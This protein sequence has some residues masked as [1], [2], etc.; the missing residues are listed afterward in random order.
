MIS[1]TRGKETQ[2]N[3]TYR[4]LPERIITQHIP[5]KRH[6]IVKDTR[7]IE[8]H[9]TE[10]YNM[11]ISRDEIEEPEPI[12]VEKIVEKPIEVLVT[13]K[14]PKKVVR[15][16]Y[17][18]QIVEK[19]IERIIEKEIIIDKIIEKEIIKTVEVPVEK[20]VEV[21]V[22]EIIEKPVE[23]IEYVDI[24]R[25]R[26]QTKVEE[27]QVEIDLFTIRNIDIDSKDIGKYPK[28]QILPTS[29]SSTKK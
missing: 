12:I 21:A 16:V 6:S 14:I 27:P 24:P 13:R 4:E 26:I 22:E 9:K 7:F 10:S 2:I 17:Y 3:V 18:D 20:I 11:D 28:A 8:T 23:I 1:E 15:D 5:Q 19:P 25:T 29:F